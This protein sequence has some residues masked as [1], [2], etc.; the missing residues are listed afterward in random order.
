MKV[1]IKKNADRESIRSGVLPGEK[2]HGL[3]GLVVETPMCSSPVC[4]VVFSSKSQLGKE[5][6]APLS[7]IMGN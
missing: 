7:P 4:S 3:G 5:T 2:K 6:R 1:K